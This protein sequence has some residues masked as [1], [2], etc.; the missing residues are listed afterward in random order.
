[1]G[2]ITKGAIRYWPCEVMGNATKGKYS[3]KLKK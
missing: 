3:I 2:N 1:M